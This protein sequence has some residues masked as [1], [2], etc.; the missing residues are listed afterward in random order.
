MSLTV[1]LFGWSTPSGGQK[2]MAR[3]AVRVVLVF[4]P[5]SMSSVY[6]SESASADD[7]LSFLGESRSLHFGGKRRPLGRDRNL[8]GHTYGTVEAVPLEES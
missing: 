8:E 5:A 7:S 4:R 6:D 1:L 2:N 3:G